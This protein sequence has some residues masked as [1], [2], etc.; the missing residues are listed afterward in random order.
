M[1]G[2][3]GKENVVDYIIHKRVW[4][5]APLQKKHVGNENHQNILHFLDEDQL[6]PNMSLWQ[7]KFYTMNLAQNISS[8]R[9]L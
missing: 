2:T 1:K 9:L 6:V 7:F 3:N 8:L 4:L 5:S